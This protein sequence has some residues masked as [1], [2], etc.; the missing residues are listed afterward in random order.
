MKSGDKVKEG[1]QIE[2]RVEIRPEESRGGRAEDLKRKEK[3]WLRAPLQQAAD[4][5]QNRPPGRYGG[6]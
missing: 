6:D 4:L 2:I 1:S 3:W 5:N